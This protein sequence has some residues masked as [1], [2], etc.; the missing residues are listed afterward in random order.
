MQNFERNLEDNIFRIHKVLKNKTYKHSN[1]T[2]FYITDP[3]LRNI[4]KAGIDDRVIHHAVYRILY[5]IFDKSFIYDS[6]SCRLSKGTHKAV[7]RLEAFTMKVSKNYREPCFALK[8]D[9]K[10]FFASIDHQVLINLIEQRIKDKET[11]WLIK[12]II[13]SF[14]KK[15]DKGLPIGNLTSQIFANIYLAKLDQFIK[16]KLKIKHYLRYCDD[17]IILDQDYN[18]LAGI[19]KM[20][21][22]FLKNKLKL[23]L[24]KNKV[25]IR[26]F[27]QGIDF[28]GYVV[29]PHYQV[30]RTKTKK[31]MFEKVNSENLQSYLG[32]LKHCNAYRLSRDLIRDAKIR[33]INIILI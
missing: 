1:Y 15:I 5:P 4:H 11:L 7:Q 13:G 27:T 10:K 25:I 22:D 18:Y 26:K 6:Y 12:E 30:L 24:H 17:F 31:R 23:S 8:C 29:L 14:N 28:L 19:I 3:K 21:D 16:H 2:S 20:I 9:I 33:F 32:L